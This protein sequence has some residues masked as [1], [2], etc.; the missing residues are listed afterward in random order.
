YSAPTNALSLPISIWVAVSF[1]G[2]VANNLV[3]SD[4]RSSDDSSYGNA[5]WLSGILLG[6]N[7]RVRVRGNTLRNVDIGVNDFGANQAC[8]VSYNDYDS[9]RNPIAFYN[10]PGTLVPDP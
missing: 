3:V 10:G 2:V 1:D 6:T 8:V 9:V 4:V 7:V 5:N